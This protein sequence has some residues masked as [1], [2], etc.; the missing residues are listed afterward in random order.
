MRT[1]R[2]NTLLDGDAVEQAL[3]GGAIGDEA[4]EVG[5]GFLVAGGGFVPQAAA[6][7]AE[8]GRVGAEPEVAVQESGRSIKDRLATVDRGHGRRSRTAR[9]TLAAMSQSAT[10]S[11]TAPRR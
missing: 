7:P 10:V 3:A 4:V 9:T 1:L 5:V 11:L 2:Q 6:E 8:H